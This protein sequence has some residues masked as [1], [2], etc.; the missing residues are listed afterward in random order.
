MQKFVATFPCQYHTLNINRLKL[1]TACLQIHRETQTFVHT[2]KWEIIPC[3]HMTNRD[4]KTL[5]RKTCPHSLSLSVTHT[6]TMH[7]Q[8]H[9][10]HVRTHT[11]TRA[12]T[13][14]HTP[15]HTHTH[16]HIH[17]HSYLVA[18]QPLCWEDSWETH[19][20]P[21]ACSCQTTLKPNFIQVLSLTQCQ[22]TSLICL[23][24]YIYI[25]GCIIY[26]DT[27]VGR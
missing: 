18:S 16:V 11:H 13:H 25:N 26:N 10:H 22:S 6:Y 21:V 3:I 27:S 5:I 2:D 20:H 19:G 15:M 23:F 9:T 24:D 14:T 17:T 12:H 8:W 1:N 7:T 4:V